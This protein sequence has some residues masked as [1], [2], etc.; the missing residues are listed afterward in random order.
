MTKPINT[1]RRDEPWTDMEDS[2]DPM[3]HEEAVRMNAVQRYVQ[4]DLTAQEERRF[5]EHY[6]ACP[7]CAHAVAV[8]QALAGGKS[9]LQNRPPWWKRFAL[10]VLTPALAGLLSL[11]IYQNAELHQFNVAK[12]NTVILAQ[13]SLMGSESEGSLVRTAS[14]TVELVLPPNSASPFYRLRV[15]RTDGGQVLSAVI[16]APEGSRLSL[17]LPNKTLRPG[18]Y[19]VAVFGLTTQAATDGPQIGELYHFKLR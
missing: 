7:E 1:N 19:D 6:F 16:P 8:E 3:S 14:E 12:A 18:S 2:Y 13:Q 17:Q 9:P 15:S 4:N 11:V 10:P 5:E